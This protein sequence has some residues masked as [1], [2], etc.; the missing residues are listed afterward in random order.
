MELW[1]VRRRQHAEAARKKPLPALPKAR[2]ATFHEGLSAQIMHIG[3]YAA[4]APTIQKL[5]RFIAD[6]GGE[7][8]GKHHEGDP[9][10]SAPERLKTIIRQPFAR[11]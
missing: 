11:R 8:S 2:L 10:K 1:F 7:L 4:E 6:Q 9:R 3:P 5:H